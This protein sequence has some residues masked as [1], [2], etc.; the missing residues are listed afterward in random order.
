MLNFTSASR[1][2][3]EFITF[4]TGL[5]N[6]FPIC[7]IHD[8][9]VCPWCLSHG[10]EEDLKEHHVLFICPSVVTE[11]IH[12]G[13]TDYMRTRPAL[14]PILLYRDY[15]TGRMKKSVLMKRIFMAQELK[16]VFLERM[17]SC[18]TGL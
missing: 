14:S 7:D 15:W 10:I 13:I 18:L 16:H 4:N 12:T 1:I 6:R 11:R 17:M 5:G 8:I 2:Y 3:H 9:K